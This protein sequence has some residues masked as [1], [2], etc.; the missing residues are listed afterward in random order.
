MEEECRKIYGNDQIQ[1]SVVMPNPEQ[2]FAYMRMNKHVN[3]GVAKFNFK[4]NQWSETEPTNL[5]NPDA[6]ID[7]AT[8]ED[9]TILIVYNDS[10]QAR[11]ILSL[12]YS[13]DGKEFK[14]IWD[15]ENGVDCSYPALIRS[16]N[17]QFHLTYTY[18]F[19]GAIKHIS[20]NSEWIKN[21]I[22]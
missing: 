2:L 6:G 13:K 12:A 11:N 17:G 15:F 14:K 19:R 21:Q 10:Y 4:L 3:I 8:M 22:K 9:G 5:P 1:P 18:D 16:Q 20:F 7:S